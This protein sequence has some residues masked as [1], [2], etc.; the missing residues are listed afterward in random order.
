M[1]GNLS[2]VFSKLSDLAIDDDQQQGKS[3]SNVSHPRLTLSLVSV[4]LCVSKRFNFGAL[5]DENE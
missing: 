2:R 3:P 5:V 4:C 1:M